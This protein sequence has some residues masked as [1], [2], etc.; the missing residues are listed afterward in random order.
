MGI[1][2]AQACRY[3]GLKFICVTDSKTSGQN[4]KIM[5]AYGATVEV[6]RQPDPETKDF[7]QARLRRV[8]ELMAE[9]GGNGF[10]ANQYESECGMRAHLDTMNEI[11]QQAGGHVEWLFCATSSCA[12]IR[13][14][15]E[16]AQAAKLRT[17]IVAVDAVGSV[18]FG[19]KLGKR[20]LAGHGA[21]MRPPFAKDLYNQTSGARGRRVLS[22]L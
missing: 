7:L 10:W 21:G 11:C 6:V 16:Y 20:L 9:L 3:F 13:G 2:L 14:C 18:V 5:K 12:T 4:I 15:V 1:G 8:R 22:C 17:R 19:G